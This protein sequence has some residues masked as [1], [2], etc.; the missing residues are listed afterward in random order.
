MPLIVAGNRII[1][2]DKLLYITKAKS[3]S[4]F[5]AQFEGDTLFMSPK[6]YK[7]VAAAIL[8]YEHN[9]RPRSVTGCTN[10]QPPV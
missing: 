5:I 1:N 9:N 10:I 4:I 6:E 3:K 8:N 2:S 7:E